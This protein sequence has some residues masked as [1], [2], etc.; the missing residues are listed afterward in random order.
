MSEDLL[1]LMMSARFRR[2]GLYDDPTSYDLDYAGYKAE[3][4]F[5]RMLAREYGREGGTYVELGAGTGRV[6]LPLAREGARVHAVEPSKAMR[7][8]LLEKLAKEEEPVRARVTVEGAR[9][10]TFRVPDGM[11]ASLIALP[12]NAVLHLETRD[13]LLRS[14][15]HVRE[16]IDEKGCFALDMTGPSWT[17]MSVGG[18]PWGRLDER[19]DPRSGA[20]V[21]TCDKT[22]YDAER[23][24]LV[25]T[26]RFLEEGRREGVELLLE[27]RMWTWQ[28]VLHALHES[29]F[30][31]ERAFGDV[32]F[33]PF[34]EK[35]PRL[36][37]AALAR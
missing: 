30:F 26:L 13:E 9:A 19:T 34:H 33:S 7:K 15:A 36:L 2:A 1:E 35:S 18:Y 10:D 20:R 8:G 3:L 24:V 37:V 4:P 29:G 25:S 16:Q 22:H 31:V 14:F 11:R 21:L 12:F 6:V 5:Y 17:V 23:R 28:E 32:D 27:Q